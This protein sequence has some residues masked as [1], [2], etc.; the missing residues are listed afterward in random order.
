MTVY[1]YQGGTTYSCL[2]LNTTAL[3]VGVIETKILTVEI[4]FREGSINIPLAE[5]QY[6]GRWDSVRQRLAGAA[7]HSSNIYVLCRYSQTV[8][9]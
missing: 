2:Y 4:C 9:G 6:E 1:Y 7:Q 8:T 3:M 5:L